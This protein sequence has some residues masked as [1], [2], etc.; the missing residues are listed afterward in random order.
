MMIDERIQELTEGDAKK[1]LR[2]AVEEMAGRLSCEMCA[3]RT[4]CGKDA[5][6]DDCMRQV[7]VMLAVPRMNEEDEETDEPEKGVIYY[8][9]E[10]MRIED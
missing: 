8:D 10:T 4:A 9:T 6:E 2:R 5:T 3:M 1:L 7:L